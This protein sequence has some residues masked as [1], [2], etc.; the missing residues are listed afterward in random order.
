MQKK[1][2]LSQEGVKKL[3]EE[4]AYLENT[5]RMEVSKMIQVAKEQGDLSENA[6]YAAA[7]DLQSVTEGRIMEL[8][9]MLKNVEIISTEG[10][11]D[12]VGLGA[13]VTVDMDGEDMTYSIVGSSEADPMGG[14]ISNES[15]IGRAILGKKPGDMVSVKIPAGTVTYKIKKI[16]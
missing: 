15:P 4:L 9:E 16:H 13:T 3:E 6:E 2:Y 14:K 5:R 7:K 1:V 10:K 11:R 8:H 12:V